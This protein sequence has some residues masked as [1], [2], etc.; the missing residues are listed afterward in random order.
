MMRLTSRPAMRPASFVAWRWSSLK[1]AGTVMTAESTGSP[2]YASASAFSFWRIIAEISGG[3]YCLPDACTRASP[4]DPETTLY[5]TIDSS[6][7]T[8]A[9]LRPMKRLMEKTVFVGLVTAWRLATVPTSRSP[10]WVNATTDGVVRPPSE[11]S[12]TVGSPPSK[13]AMHEF[14]VP[15]SMP[16]VLAMCDAPCKDLSRGDADCSRS[17]TCVEGRIPRMPVVARGTSGGRAGAGSRA[18]RARAHARDVR[19]DRHVALP[20]GEQQHAGGRLAADAGQG[21]QEVAILE[22]RTVE[23]LREHAQ[24]LLDAPGLD[25]GDA[26]GADRL[27]DLLVRGVADGL[28]GSEAAAQPQEGDV[29]VAVVGRLRE[30]GQD[31]LVEAAAVRR[32]HGDAVDLAQAVADAPHAGTVGSC[33][34]ASYATAP[35]DSVARAPAPITEIT[36]AARRSGPRAPHRASGRAW[37]GSVREEGRALHGILHLALK[38]SAKLPRTLLGSPAATDCAPRRPLQDTDWLGTPKSGSARGRRIR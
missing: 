25:L 26:A 29:A 33:S 4:P 1:Y 3:E 30:H 24:D 22:M 28:P 31:Q 17:G 10:P 34:G 11:F 6:S 23:R 7:C 13:T 32:R 2:R 14:V 19:V 16:M 15:R 36:R 18:A 27:L 5:G 12:I 21:E 8:S 37:P 35:H 20:V 38:V 9:S